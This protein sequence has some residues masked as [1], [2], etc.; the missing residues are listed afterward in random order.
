MNTRIEQ[1]YLKCPVFLQN[2]GIS[3]LGLK[4]NITRY[5]GIYSKYYKSIV[6]NLV[7]SKAEID[8]FQLNMLKSVIYNASVEVPYY[9]EI[10]KKYQ[11]PQ[12][13]KFKLS[14]IKSIP[15]LLKKQIK[16]DPLT[17][18]NRQFNEKELITLH[19]TG[20]TG[21]PLKLFCTPEV[22]QRNYAFFSR[23]LNSAG[24]DPDGTRI[25]IGGRVIVKPDQS[26]PPFWRY[27]LFQKSILMSS[28][29]LSEKN[30]DSYI[31][32]IKKN[33]PSYIDT[34][35]SSINII[36]QFA[37]QN[38]ISLNG[39]TK[40]IITSAETLHPYQKELI[41][42]VFGVPVYDQYGAAEMCVFIA[43]CRYGRYHLHSDYSFVEFLKDNGTDAGPGEE[44][45][46]VCTGFIN[47]V[48]PLIRY[49]IG[50]SV[51]LS[52]ENCKCGCNFPV[53]EKILGREDDIIM[54]ADGRRI[55]RLSPV[56]K[57]F[58]IVEAQYRQYKLN[59]I[60][61]LIVKS[62]EYGKETEIK[63][64]EELHKRTG[65]S[66]IITIKYVERIER[67]TG[68]KLRSVISYLGKPK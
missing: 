56:L 30:I 45:E 43:Q 22:R 61:L 29:H 25:T 54:T 27:S 11:L 46:I 35:P 39:V 23:F 19:T 17:L 34:Y 57:G 7:K 32:M 64:I 3:I 63:I 62:P 15:F 26:K 8:E 5:A 67:E 24:I 20:T 21:T 10:F 14:D 41:E 68:N 55:G 36:A 31:S 1:I 51:I 28:Y 9:R 49:K 65:S 48:M 4:E 66:M 44:A 59:E 53:I 33:K 58:P 60:E 13:D 50:D 37:Y 52:K 47:T 16:E 38:K 2:T 18:V 42:K 6:T 12:K 40:R